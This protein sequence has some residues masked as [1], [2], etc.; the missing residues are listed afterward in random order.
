MLLVRRIVLSSDELGLGEHID[1]NVEGVPRRSRIGDEAHLKVIIRSDRPLSSLKVASAEGI[2]V[3]DPFLSLTGAEGAME[4]RMLV[5]FS[6]KEGEGKLEISISTADVGATSGRFECELD[7]RPRRTAVSLVGSPV[8]WTGEGALSFDLKL[9]NPDRVKGELSARLISPDGAE[10][11][12]RAPSRSKVSFKGE[13]LA[14]M[15]LV[16]VDRA[17]AGEHDLDVNLSSDAGGEYLFEGA[18]IVPE[19]AQGLGLSAA[20]AGSW[21]P[22]SISDHAGATDARMLIGQDQCPLPIRASQG[23]LEVQFPVARI[24][25]ARVEVLRG[26]D[27][28]AVGDVEVSPPTPLERIVV[29]PSEAIVMAGGD[30]FCKISYSKRD[31]LPMKAVMV[32]GGE[33]RIRAGSDLDGTDGDIVVPFRVPKDHPTGVQP[34]VIEVIREGVAIYRSVRSD[35][36][37]IMSEVS[38]VIELE[39]PSASGDAILAPYLFPGEEVISSETMG[40]LTVHEL[41]T[42]RRMMSL[43]GQLVRG[44][45]WDE[46]RDAQALAKYVEV[47]FRD[48]LSEQ[49]FRRK[50]NETLGRLQSMGPLEGGPLPPLSRAYEAFSGGGKDDPIVLKVRSFSAAILSGREAKANELVEAAAA[51][52]KGSAV[53]DMSGSVACLLRCARTASGCVDAIGGGRR[54]T[55]GALER[56][57]NE[58][59][60]MVLLQVELVSAW[61]D[62]AISAWDDLRTLRQRSVRRSLESA[63]AAMESLESVS[64]RAKGRF[65]SMKN[66]MAI[67]RGLAAVRELTLK[68]GPP[69]SLTPT[70]TLKGTISVQ[71]GVEGCG[72]DVHISSMQRSWSVIA[73]QAPRDRIGHYLGRYVVGAGSVLEIELEL[74]VPQGVRSGVVRLFIKPDRDVLEAEP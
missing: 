26:S 23:H 67:R 70:G 4:A 39:V 38:S 74:G 32:I 66:N 63:I 19:R 51:T 22:T 49:G 27:V 1:L 41:S 45:G 68:A 69:F 43:D 11:R 30:S 48:A 31:R 72:M 59:S 15:E 9:V 44:R 20:A 35:A 34:M 55:T 36:I 62:P 53:P 13:L 65:D 6:G 17:G 46:G 64:R 42:G 16:P 47:L 73:P 29:T 50:L 60:F 8:L 28:L 21:T 33:G 25:K 52:I 7:L 54:A 37:T 2:D 18:V 71:G 5:R 24:G 57:L 3:A 14:P 56:A 61:S 10:V 12:L 58:L 40:G